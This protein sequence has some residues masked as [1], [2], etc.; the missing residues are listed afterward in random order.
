MK[1]RTD[2][3]GGRSGKRPGGRSGDRRGGAFGGRAGREGEDCLFPPDPVAAEEAA[4]FAAAAAAA[5]EQDPEAARQKGIA[6]LARRDY[7]SA[8]LRERLLAV[9]FTESAVE[10]AILAL[11]NAGFLDDERYAEH[12]VAYHSGRGQGPRRIRLEMRGKGLP[13]HLIAGAINEAA[14]VWA[15]RA[16]ALRRRRFGVD[17]PGTLEER[18]RQSRFLLYRGFTPAQVRLAF[19]VDRVDLEDLDLDADMPEDSAH[20]D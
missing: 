19:V 2:R 20:V 12:F 16:Q 7:G 5:R 13:E 3:W 9:P 17:A 18:A 6:L 8:E 4:A 10:T 11:E 14:P 15:E 1:R